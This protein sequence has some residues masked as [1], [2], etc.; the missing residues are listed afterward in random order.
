MRK[1]DAVAL[2]LFAHFHSHSFTRLLPAN[3]RARLRVECVRVFEILRASLVFIS[4]S[5]LLSFSLSSI[6]RVL[7]NEQA[8]H[9]SHSTL[10][11]TCSD[12]VMSSSYCRKSTSDL[13]TVTESSTAPV[14]SHHRRRGSS[15]VSRHFA[16]IVIIIH[17]SICLPFQ[18]QSF[19]IT[20]PPPFPRYHV[21]GSSF[22]SYFCITASTFTYTRRHMHSR[23]YRTDK[24]A[25]NNKTKTVRIVDAAVVIHSDVGVCEIIRVN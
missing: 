18:T 1:R 5:L 3:E 25:T 11:R 23:R 17:P 16:I 6:S 4:I 19:L 15:K 20:V 24:W 9:T 22:A 14:A 10:D 12:S 2:L 7:L 21:W 8:L 13:T